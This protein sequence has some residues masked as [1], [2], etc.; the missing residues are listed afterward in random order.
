MGKFFA[1]NAVPRSRGLGG[2]KQPLIGMLF[3]LKKTGINSKHKHTNK[4]PDFPHAIRLVPRSEKL[5]VTKT[6]ENL[7]AMTV[8]ILMNITDSK[9]GTILSA[10]DTGS[11]LFLISAPFINAKRF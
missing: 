2:T 4:F 5:Q 7:L 11:E 8:L 3:C 6:P 9:E 1:A 10:I